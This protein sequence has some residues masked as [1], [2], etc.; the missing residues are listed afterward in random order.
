MAKGRVADI[1]SKRNRFNQI[2]IEIQKPP[3]GSR[4]FGNKLYVEDP[5]RNM[6]IFDQIKDL[7]FINV[8]GIGQGMEYP[9][10]I[11]GKSL[12]IFRCL[13]FLRKFSKTLRTEGRSRGE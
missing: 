8:S 11:D 3:D 12:S 6:I 1:V 13:M 5:M 10:H 4:N 2:L 7:G 9:V